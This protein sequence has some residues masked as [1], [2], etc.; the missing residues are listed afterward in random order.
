M[1]SLFQAIFSCAVAYSEDILCELFS[2]ISY[3]RCLYGQNILTRPNL[4]TGTRT[5]PAWLYQREHDIYRRRW[6]QLMAYAEALVV[7]ERSYYTVEQAS[8]MDF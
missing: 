5:A 6:N 1:K 3:R 2:K 7:G 8:G 4:R